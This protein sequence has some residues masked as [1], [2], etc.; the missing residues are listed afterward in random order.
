MDTLYGDDEYVS[1]RAPARGAT[2]HIIQY[3]RIKKF[4]F[5]LP[6]GERRIDS[7]GALGNKVFQFALPRGER[8]PPGLPGGCARA[9]FQ[10]ALPRGERQNCSVGISAMPS[11]N[12]RS[13]EGSD[14]IPLD[15][16][17]Q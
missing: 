17:L 13:R 5:A 7:R 1:I 11:F 16:V 9:R 14:P 15:S 6:R 2:F 3:L 12:S 8:L 10:F 4:Q